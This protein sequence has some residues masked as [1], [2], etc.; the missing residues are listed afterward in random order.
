MK[1]K[2]TTYKKLITK[3]NLKMNDTSP[4]T[5]HENLNNSTSNPKPENNYPNDIQNLFE[6]LGLI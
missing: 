6:R 4:S 2:D 5:T 3:K 1:K